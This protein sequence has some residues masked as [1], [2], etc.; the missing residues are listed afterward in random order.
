MAVAGFVRLSNEQ[1]RHL[2]DLYQG[3]EVLW[4]TESPAY[5]NNVLRDRALVSIQTCMEAKFGLHIEG[6]P[7][8]VLVQSKV[9]CSVCRST[10]GKIKFKA[11]SLF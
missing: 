10:S 5:K 9:K 6:R 2:I 8:S 11:W 4:N 1:T 7:T 3:H